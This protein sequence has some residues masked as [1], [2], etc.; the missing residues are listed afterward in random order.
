MVIAY[1][2]KD[3]DYFFINKGLI[4]FFLKIL[5]LSPQER[6]DAIVRYGGFKN[7]RAFVSALELTSPQIIY[8]IQSGKTKGISSKLAERIS[9][10]FP[11]IRRGWIFTGEGEML[12]GKES[13]VMTQDGV[14][15]PMEL[16]RMF[17]NMTDAARLQEE[18]V[19]RLTKIVDRLTGGTGKSD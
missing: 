10:V 19:S 3:K 16:V 1:G 13:G 4:R 2:N 11:E 9:L 14:F 12:D 5:M 6:I 8:D 15:I 17:T 18:N 7:I